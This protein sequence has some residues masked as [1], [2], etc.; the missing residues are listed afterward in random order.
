[1]CTTAIKIANERKSSILASNAVHHRVDSLTSIV[2][3]LA[4]GGSHIFNN[5]TWL[6]PIGG[7]LVS[8]MVIRAG[9]S[10]TMA[11]GRELLDV[12][13]DDEVKESL[14]KAAMTAL[15][16]GIGSLETSEISKVEVHDIQGIKAGQKYRMD[17]ELAVPSTWSMKQIQEVERTVRERVGL[18]VRMLG[19]LRIRFVTIEG[20]KQDFTDEFIGSAASA[21]EVDVATEEEHEHDH[22]HEH[23]DHSKSRKL[24]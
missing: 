7:L 8:L 17:L 22:E 6:D 5:A 21:A 4:I 10:N 12:S 9:W 13:V 24:H 15:R 2:A 3:L 19:K 23:L 14:R 18:R 1:M 16:D 11:A 20:E